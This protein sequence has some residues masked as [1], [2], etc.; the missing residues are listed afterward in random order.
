MGKTLTA[1]SNDLAEAVALAS[2]ELVR[3]EARRRMPASGILWN[4]PG[5]IVTANHVV[6]R[7][8]KI[9]IGSPDGSF[10]DA[11]LVGRDPGS[12]LAV[13]RAESS[14][15]DSRWADPKRLKVGHLVLALGRPAQQVMAT[16][17]VISV[18]GQSIRVPSGSRMDR[19]IQTDVVMYPGF[20][21]GPLVSASGE[22][23]GMNT[24][25]LIRG[26]SV[27]LPWDWIDTRVNELLEHG[28]IRRGYLGVSLQ[29][30]RI[31][32][33]LRK[34]LDQETGLLIAGVEEKSPAEQAGL[35]QGDVL[36]TAN[37]E[38]IRSL[39][40]LLNQLTAENIGSVMEMKLVRSG[41]P[42]QLEVIVGE[43]K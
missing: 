25:G 39:D 12:D 6:E 28:F 31:P 8:E 5:I 14:P 20:S 16:H 15:K 37:G 19:L 33:G 9:R 36:I 24:S 40:D 34:E 4:K 26:I 43:G 11:E 27:A 32:T 7:D 3:V 10:L 35:Y 22:I 2:S 41:K 1:L 30:V 21:G 23:Y 13:L 38:P 42:L 18:L 29:P 17:G